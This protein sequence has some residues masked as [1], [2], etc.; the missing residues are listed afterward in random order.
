MASQLCNV[1]LLISG[2]CNLQCTYCYAQ[3]GGVGGKQPAVMSVET[4]EL[5]LDKLL[6]EHTSFVISFFGGEPLL[7][8][9]LMRKTV[10]IGN[11][12]G[13]RRNTS[14]SYALTTN[15]TLLEDEHLDFL[16]ENIDYLAVSLDGGQEFTDESRRYKDGEGSVYQ[17]VVNNLR[18]LERAGIPYGLRGTVPEHLAGMASTVVAHLDSL[19]ARSLRVDPAFGKAPWRPDSHR[20]WLSCLSG[21]NRHSL[22]CILADEKPSL[23]SEIYRVAG[24]RLTKGAERHYPC[25]AGHGILAVAANGDVYPCDHFVGVPE[26]CMGNVVAAD[27]PNQQ[28]RRIADQMKGNA[29]TNRGRCAKC[30][31]KHMCG[32]EC[33]AHSWVRQGCISDPSPDFCARTRYLIRE[34]EA[35]LDAVLDSEASRQKILSFLER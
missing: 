35:S 13:R 11:E 18:R 32:G 2:D 17:A 34:M 21:I 22:E 25:L 30:R 19:G 1:Y 6:P 10:A 26:F 29:V 31:V 4:M 12:L 8:F 3:G 9:D 15:G 7:N 16:R 23:T 14:V 27:F 24:Y 5:S 33:P 28:Y 20:R